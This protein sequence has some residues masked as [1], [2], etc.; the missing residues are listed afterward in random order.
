MLYVC[1][2]MCEGVCEGGCMCVRVWVW[3][4]YTLSLSHCQRPS[5]SSQRTSCPS[6]H[7][8]NS[9]PPPPPHSAPPPPR[10]VTDRGPVFSRESRGGSGVWESGKGKEEEEEGEELTP[11]PKRVAGPYGDWTTVAIQS[12]IQLSLIVYCHFWVFWLL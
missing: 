6:Q 3:R 5:G 2:C 12:V 9:R 1:V 7:S 10:P 11:A 4:Y 8:L